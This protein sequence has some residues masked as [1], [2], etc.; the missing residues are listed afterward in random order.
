MASVA[1]RPTGLARSDLS[2]RQMVW[3]SCLALGVVIALDLID[4]RLGILFSVGFV[5]VAGT[6][7]LAVDVR[8][9]LPSGVLPPVLLI[10][11][12]GVVC[13]LAPAAVVV[14]GMPADVGWAG[15]TLAGTVDHGITLLVGHGLAIAAVVSRI[16]TDPGHPRRA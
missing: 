6:M 3:L 2:A 10:T 12:V 7:P 11:A 5:L 8:Q 14:E 16:L 15:H 4:G 9:L 13:L 1:Q